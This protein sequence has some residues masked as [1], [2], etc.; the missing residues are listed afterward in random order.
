MFRKV[1]PKQHESAWKITLKNRKKE[2]VVVDVVE[3]MPVN[4]RILKS[5][6]PYQKTDAFTVRFSIP[7]PRDGEA[8]CTYRVR[9]GE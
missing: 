9:A 2:D 4:W 5:S 8:V 1:S 3:S 6:H 7:V